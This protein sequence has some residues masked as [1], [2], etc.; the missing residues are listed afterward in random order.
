MIN[1]NKWYAEMRQGYRASGVIVDNDGIGETELQ[2]RT[3]NAQRAI[4]LLNSIWWDNQMGINN[5]RI[6]QV[7]VEWVLCYGSEIWAT[8]EEE[9]RKELTLE[10]DYLQKSG[11]MSRLEQI[12]N[13]KVGNRTS[14]QETVVQRIEKRG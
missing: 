14:A 11:R 9:K 6:G 5:K 12:C 8:K 10:M 2:H 1:Q 4:G 13:E 7:M 3:L